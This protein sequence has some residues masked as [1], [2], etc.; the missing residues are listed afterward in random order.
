MKNIHVLQ[1]E[2]FIEGYKQRAELGDAIFDNTSRMFAI[3]LFKK[4]KN[5]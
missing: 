4:F 3:D 1:M 2:S 5:K